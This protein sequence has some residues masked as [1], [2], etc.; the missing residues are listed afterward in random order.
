MAADADVTAGHSGA[1][2]LG[3]TLAAGDTADHAS[4]VVSGLSAGMTL[5]SGHNNGDGSWTL[6]QADLAHVE[7]TAPSNVIGDLHLA[8]TGIAQ[9]ESGGAAAQTHQDFTVHVHA[10]DHANIFQAVPHA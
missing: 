1:L 4:A 2:T 7:L 10:D 8:L 3:V 6:S 9:N 5:S